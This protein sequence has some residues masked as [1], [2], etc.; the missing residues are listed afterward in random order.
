MSDLA[1]ALYKQG[2]Q[3]T[4]SDVA[5]TESALSSLESVSL[6]PE[7][8]GWFPKKITKKLDKVIVGQQVSPANPE[9]QTAQQVDL[10]ILSYP[11]YVYD[12]AQD[13]QRIVVTGEKEQRTL[14]SALVVHVLAF[15][16]KAAD[17]VVDVK[18]LATTAQ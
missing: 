9:L 13:K 8:S 4:G 10:P 7:Q 15:H 16:N 6:V 5:F 11:Q 3:I 1:A 18:R 12:Y 2:H 17:Y 14:I